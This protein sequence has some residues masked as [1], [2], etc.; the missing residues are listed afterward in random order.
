VPLDPFFLRF[1]PECRTDSLD[2]Y[3]AEIAARLPPCGRILD[4]GC[5]ANHQLAGFG[6]ERREVWG[7]DFHEHPELAHREWFRRLAPDG[8]IPFPNASF[9]LVA[10]CWVLE[11]VA[12]P[13]PFLHEVSRVLRPGGWFVALTPNGWH[14]ATGLIRLFEL[15]PHRLAQRVVRRLYGRAH[16]DTFRTYYRLNSTSRL[17]KAAR[18][19]GMRLAGRLGFPNPDYFSFS[20]LLRSA[21]VVTDYVLE[22]LRPGLGQLYQ[23]VTLHKPAEADRIHQPRAA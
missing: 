10:A 14:Y 23:V 3:L 2:G 7:A 12:R 16:H 18:S 13:G 11:H 6:T 22:R 9:D 8:G 1:F 21:A 19:A 20:P 17:T 5:G 15:L 4:L